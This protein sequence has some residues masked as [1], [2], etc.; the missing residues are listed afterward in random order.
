MLLLAFSARLSAA[1]AWLTA[2]LF[3]LISLAVHHGDSGT[4]LANGTATRS[5]GMLIFLGHDDHRRAAWRATV[6]PLI[7]PS[8]PNVGAWAT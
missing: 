3:A 2:L 6:R 4:T 5:Y 1:C 8:A 7:A